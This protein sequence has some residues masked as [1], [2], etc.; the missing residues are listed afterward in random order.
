MPFQYPGVVSKR[1]LAGNVKPLS[2]AVKTSL[3]AQAAKDLYEVSSEEEAL[4]LLADITDFV[5]SME[6]PSYPS[7]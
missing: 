1:Y 5:R 6:A 3:C 2:R 7:K 4:T